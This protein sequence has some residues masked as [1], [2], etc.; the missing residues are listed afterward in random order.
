MEKC[1]EIFRMKDGQYWFTCYHCGIE[2][3]SADDILRHINK[4]HF[5]SYI[6]HQENLFAEWYVVKSETTNSYEDVSPDITT[7]SEDIS[8]GIKPLNTEI[9]HRENQSANLDVL[10]SETTNYEDISSG[11]TNSENILSGIVPMNIEKHCQLIGFTV[12]KLASVNAKDTP[13]STNEQNDAADETRKRNGNE[14]RSIYYQKIVK[15]PYESDKN[16]KDIQLICEDC[17]KNFKSNKSMR[18]HQCNH[19]NT[20]MPTTTTITGT[21]KS[22]QQ[23][24]LCLKDSSTSSSAKTHQLIQAKDR[25]FTCDICSKQF[26]AFNRLRHH[27]FVV[28]ADNRPYECTI[29]AKRYGEASTLKNH[30]L[31]HSQTKPFGCDICEKRFGYLVALRSHMVVHSD[32]VKPYLCE[33]CSRTFTQRSNLKTHMVTHG[34]EKKH[35][36][37]I[38]SRPFSRADAL[39]THILIHRPNKTKLKCTICD[40]DF[41]YKSTLAKHIL[42]H[43]NGQRFA[44]N[45]CTKRFVTPSKL[46]LHQMVHTDERPF[47][48]TICGVHFKRIEDMRKHRLRLHDVVVYVEK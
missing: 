20:T 48:C 4:N 15:K 6:H 31:T 42:I 37:E 47:S 39:K 25:P 22:R 7:N 8:S 21:S 17:G 12:E 10:K 43:T 36:C 44:C 23:S 13:T 46:K 24:K 34:K 3:G 26:S 1:G 29:C 16:G 18:N 2:K 9:N 19:I 32:N 40:K 35:I 28:H 11:T 30:M 33:I 14:W 5:T 45:I 41:G 27:I 38:C